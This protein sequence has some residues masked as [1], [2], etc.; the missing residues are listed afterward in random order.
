M[1]I[2]FD[3]RKTHF[4][5]TFQST[6]H[7]VSFHAARIKGSQQ[8]LKD[9]DHVPSEGEKVTIFSWLK[10]GYFWNQVS[11]G[12]RTTF[13]KKVWPLG[14]LLGCGAHQQSVAPKRHTAWKKLPKNHDFGTIS[15]QENFEAPKG[16]RHSK[17]FKTCSFII[18]SSPMMLGWC[19][20]ST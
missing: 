5:S 14:T 8:V 10:I 6:R 7:E 13:L 4:V 3:D 9:L 20:L 11:D 12:D 17:C 18:K 16:P 19:L 1:L 15:S 2:T